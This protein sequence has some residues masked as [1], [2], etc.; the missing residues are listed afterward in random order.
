V[1][2]DAFISDPA[3]MKNGTASRTNDS[4]SA[5]VRWTRMI[6][7]MRSCVTKKRKLARI[8]TNAI[9]TFSTASTTS[10]RPIAR[11]MSLLGEVS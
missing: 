1:I 8:S 11:S 9:G 2:P 7:V 10:A 6:G 5:T 3:R 4:I